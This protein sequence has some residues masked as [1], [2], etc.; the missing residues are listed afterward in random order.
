MILSTVCG[1][2]TAEKTNKPDFAIHELVHP[3]L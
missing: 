3:L 2:V 1:H